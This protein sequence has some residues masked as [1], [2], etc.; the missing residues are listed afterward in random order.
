[1]VWATATQTLWSPITWRR[2]S[3]QLGAWRS[4]GLTIR[5]RRG[6]TAGHQPRA[7]GTVYI[8]CGPGLAPHRRSRLTSNV[9]PRNSYTLRAPGFTTSS[10]ARVF[11]V[12]RTSPAATNTFRA[13]KPARANVSQS[14]EGHRR[15]TPARLR[16]AT[17]WARGGQV[18]PSRPRFGKRASRRLTLRSSRGPTAGRQ[19]R[20]VVGHIIVLAGLASYR[21]PRLTSNVRPRNS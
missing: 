15:A 18:A 9:R 10:S 16:V 3:P 13:G 2:S 19:A 21:R 1:M 11:L 5:S 20:E 12:L 6:P 7:T 8:F 4:R 17:R 14:V